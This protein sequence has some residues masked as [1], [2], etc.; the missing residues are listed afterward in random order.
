VKPKIVLFD[1]HHADQATYRQALG[2]QFDV[3][4]TD[5]GL[6]AETVELAADAEVVAIHVTSPVTAQMLKLMP[7]L[8]HVACRSTGI[9]HVDLVYA[10][11]HDISVSSVPSYGENT[12][13]EYTFML[14]LAVSRRLIPAAHSLGA[15]ALDVEQLTGHDLA[16]KTLGVIGTGKIGLRVAAIGRGFGMAVV[17]YDLY[18][19]ER[20]A[21]DI[22][23][24]YLD[25]DDLLSSA[26]CISL[27]AP[28]TPETNHLLNQAAFDR[29]KPGALIVNTARGQLID[30]P[31]LID[32]LTSGQVG[33]A[34]LDVLEGEEYLAKARETRLLESKAP[35]DDAK[36]ALAIDVLTKMPNV[37]ITGHNAY[38]SVEALGRIR[39]TTISNVLAW[40]KHLAENLVA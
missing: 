1:V 10:K 7:K 2:A 39:D 20:A 23:F 21:K 33:G 35:G 12:V 8:K 22:G 19:N 3:V 4:I 36:Q 13:A 27:H 17:A 34:G 28:A 5:L 16:G 25:L 31:A 30:T 14:L 40:H 26:D 37:L 38:N 9:D 15:G 29:M 18:P 6:S 11:Q 32:A 24:E